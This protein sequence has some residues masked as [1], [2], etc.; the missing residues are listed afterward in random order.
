MGLPK[1]GGANDSQNGLPPPWHAV[2]ALRTMK[3]DQVLE[4]A[5]FLHYILIED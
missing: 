4:Q 1:L 3:F 2:A 5:D